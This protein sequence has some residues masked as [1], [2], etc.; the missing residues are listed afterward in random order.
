M[1][2]LIFSVA[3]L[4]VSIMAVAQE[5]PPNILLII[6][7]QH[8]GS[9][10]TQRGYPHLQTPGIDKIA[11]QGVTFTRSYCALPVCQSS[12][13]SILTGVM[14]LRIN[15]PTSYPSLAKTLNTSGYE[16]AYFGKWHV[17][18]TD[19]DE[20][21]AWHGF[22]T[23]EDGHNDTEIRTNSINFLKQTRDKPFFLMTSF[24][25]PHDCCELARIIA[26]MDDNYHDGPVEEHMDTAFCPPLPFNFAIPPNEAEGFY[27]RRNQEPGDEYWNSHPTTYWTEVE[28]RQYMYGYDRLVE[29]VDAH[30][31][32]LVNELGSLNILENTVIIYTSDHGDG[33][34][35]HN[36]NQKKSFYEESI[37]IPFIVSWKGQTKAGLIDQET[38][39]NNGLDLYPTMLKLAG[40]SVPASL[41]GVD[42]RPAF[43]QDP[44]GEEQVT[45]DYVVS[46]IEQKV[47]T[48]HTPGTFAG[49]MLVFGKLKYILFDRGVN[50]EQLFDL[51]TDPGELNPVTDNSEY[52]EQLISCRKMLKEWV[53]QTSD[54]FDVDNILSEYES[55]AGLDAISIND[56]TLATFKPSLLTYTLDLEYTDSVII[57]AVPVNSGSKLTITQAEDLWGDIEARTAMINIVSEDASITRV[58]SIVLN[59]AEY[60]TQE[61]IA[62]LSEVRI[63]AMPLEGFKPEL[64]SYYQELYYN[65]SVFFEIIPTI[66]EA[67]VTILEPIDI[68]G[69]SD[70]RTAH[71]MVVSR[72]GTQSNAYHITIEIT[73]MLYKTGFIDTGSDTPDMGW[74]RS[75]GIIS[76]NIDGP[77]NHGEYEG[78]GAFKFIRG[79]ED[80]A[81][82]LSTRL[83]ENV[84]SL[85]FWMF[86]HIPDSSAKLVLETQTGSEEKRSL[87]VITSTDL[88]DTKWTKFSF[89]INR[90]GLTRMYFTPT[91]PNDGDTRFWMD[92][93]VI[94]T[95]IPDQP[96]SIERSEKGNVSIYPNPSS[97]HI[98]VTVKGG[99]AG[100][101][102]I[103]NLAGQLIISKTGVSN[104][105][106]IEIGHLD[107]GVYMLKVET[108]TG[109]SLHK[110]VKI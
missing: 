12:R 45:R 80:K 67:T 13:K 25:N 15:D 43:L 18:S 9:I 22:E 54:N 60:L 97:D 40:L 29:K 2:R 106:Q 98:M 63:N 77:G 47:Y 75:Y 53:V 101:I 62:T 99:S 26:G 6:T 21:K 65:D 105:Q 88:S 95:V 83:Y 37:N 96:S 3:L 48:G 56:S 90:E 17:G 102:D 72:D 44:G 85:S 58:Y 70:E 73:D 20:D 31:E 35:S 107:S 103:Y 100:R 46:E 30:I 19:M 78:E 61:S 109:V 11:D 81:G 1:N 92:D 49:R 110:F 74:D 86:L 79:Q 91:L 52:M 64:F 34:A 27:G 68:W 66:G 24:Q 5:T 41:H 57:D 82:Y 42:L 84:K 87:G 33:H 28:W 8:A 16:T 104:V 51:E 55:N 71:I 50:R 59:V 38:L 4:F 93:L 94:R 7:D 32:A 108:E 39:V 76:E 69:D 10:M 36:W 14:P 89:D 23:Y